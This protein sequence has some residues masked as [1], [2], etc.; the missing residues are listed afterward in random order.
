ME[1]TLDTH[2]ALNIFSK[3]KCMFR[4]KLILGEKTI[5]TCQFCITNEDCS[6]N[7]IKKIC[8]PTFKKCVECF[9]ENEDACIPK[10]MICKFLYILYIPGNPTILSC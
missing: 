6:S 8:H 9:K 1:C 7:E 2:C 10:G 3:N 4:N 5:F